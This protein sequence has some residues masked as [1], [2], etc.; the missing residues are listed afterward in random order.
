MYKVKESQLPKILYS[1]P[2]VKY[3]GAKKGNLIK[4]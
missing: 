1:D 4:I 3:L 2:M